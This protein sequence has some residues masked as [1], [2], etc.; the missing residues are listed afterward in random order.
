M[1]LL[2]SWGLGI[3]SGSAGRQESGVFPAQGASF[4]LGGSGTRVHCCMVLSA[5]L[6]EGEGWSARGWSVGKV[7]EEVDR[8]LVA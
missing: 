7:T 6:D 5:F 1:P 2:V 8:G 3:E 4:G